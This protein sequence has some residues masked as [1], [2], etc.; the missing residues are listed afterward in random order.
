M[1]ERAVP[2]RGRCM[3]I[4][5][6]ED[7]AEIAALMGSGFEQLGHE[8]TMAETGE[9]RVLHAVSRSFDAIILDLML[10]D[11]TVFRSCRRSGSQET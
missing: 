8:V 7:D 10:A 4:L 6:I 9:E 3:K 5:V 1:F 2:E 11:L